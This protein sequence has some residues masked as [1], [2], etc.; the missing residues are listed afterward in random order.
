MKDQFDDYDKRIMEKVDQEAE[1]IERMIR[2]DSEIAS[3][4]ADANLDAKVY[5]SVSAYED[6]VAGRRSPEPEDAKRKSWKLYILAGKCWNAA[7]KGR[8]GELR[9][10]RPENG[11]ILRLYS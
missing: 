3:I 10:R 7:G 4:R 5:E 6:G 1:E 2:A 8:T 11:S 9:G